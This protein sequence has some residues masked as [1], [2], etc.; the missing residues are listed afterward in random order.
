[1]T[2][3]GTPVVCE[4]SICSCWIGTA[5]KCAYARRCCYMHAGDFCLN[6]DGFAMLQTV[7]AN[8]A[9]AATPVILLT[10]LQELAHMLM[11]MT[12]S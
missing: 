12:S 10:S 3:W 9:L 1:M 2:G 6:K 11:G 4:L 5:L 7:R 8:A